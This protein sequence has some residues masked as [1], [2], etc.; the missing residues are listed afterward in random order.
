MMEN[1]GFSG[2]GNKRKR[3]QEDLDSLLQPTS[4][5][6]NEDRVKDKNEK[7]IEFHNG[8]QPITINATHMCYTYMKCNYDDQMIGSPSFWHQILV[9][10][11]KI[12][13][14]PSSEIF[15]CP[16]DSSPEEV[17]RRSTSNSKTLRNHRWRTL[18]SHRLSLISDS[19]LLLRPQSRQ[20]T[21]EAFRSKLAVL[22]SRSACWSDG[23]ILRRPVQGRNVAAS[24]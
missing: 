13:S 18:H 6:N 3:R 12:E 10:R 7:K 5:T 4:A 8:E 9:C 19:W 2:G 14:A 15:L 22:H 1:L 11:E 21:E 24:E 16:L 17:Q 20:S 23:E